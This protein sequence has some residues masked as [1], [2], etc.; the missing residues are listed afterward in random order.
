VSAESGSSREDAS[1]NVIFWSRNMPLGGIVTPSEALAGQPI[2][3][4]F[5]TTFSKVMATWYELETIGR[6][7]G[8]LLAVYGEMPKVFNRVD[9]M[10]SAANSGSVGK[11]SHLEVFP[12]D[13]ALLQLTYKLVQQLNTGDRLGTTVTASKFDSK[14]GQVLTSAET[15]GLDHFFYTGNVTYNGNTFFLAKK[16]PVQVNMRGGSANLIITKSI[17]EYTDYVT[18]AGSTIFDLSGNSVSLSSSNIIQTTLSDNVIGY[19]MSEIFTERITSP[20]F[21]ANAIWDYA[22]TLTDLKSILP[23]PTTAL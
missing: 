22:E 5:E 16:I 12:E 14:I 6:S 15:A 2:L 3:F 10:L 17:G 20:F 21:S 7:S 4:D 19:R 13:L 1:G 18:Q 23:I 9:H 11:T 8:N